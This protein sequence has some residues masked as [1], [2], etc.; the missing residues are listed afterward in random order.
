MNP[1]L[2]DLI[3]AADAHQTWQWVATFEPAD[4]PATGG[5]GVIVTMVQAA[6]G[7]CL[8]LARHERAPAPHQHVAE[9]LAVLLEGRLF[10]PLGRDAP[11]GPL[12]AA[13]PAAL[14]ADAY[15]RH[16]A[17][18]VRDLRGAFG[19]V[20]WDSRAGLLLAARDPLGSHPFYFAA[21]ADSL[22]F[23]SSIDALLADG[24]LP[25]TL[26]RPAIVDRLLHRHRWLED[27]YF[28]AIHRLPPG[29]VLTVQDSRQVLRRYWDPAPPGQVVEW[30]REE[31]LPRF[32]TL[33]DAAVARGLDFGPVGVFLSGG[34]DSVTVA[35][36]A[37][38]FSR[39]RGL[40]MPR[41]YSMVFPPPMDERAVQEQAA[42]RLG[43]PQ[44]IADFAA[45]V[46]PEGVIQ[47]GLALSRTWPWPILNPWLP[48]FAALGL[49]A[50]EQGVRA[51]LSGEGGDEWLS[52]S[53]YLA[54]DLMAAGDL[55]GLW[56]LYRTLY[57]SYPWRAGRL[58]RDLT[59]QFGLRPIIGRQGRHVLRRVAPNRL[60]ARWRAIER[61][62]VPEWLAPDPDLRR[63][64]EARIDRWVAQ[65]WAAPA[66]QGYYIPDIRE[67]LD[68][69]IRAVELEE[70]HEFGR[71]WGV[72]NLQPYWDADLVDFLLRT[73]PQFLSANGRAK[74][75]IRQTLAKRLPG[76]GFE[77]Q[78]KVVFNTFFVDLM[79]GEGRRAWQQLGGAQAM[80]DHGLAD[81]KRLNE[82]MAATFAG[83]RSGDI[84]RSH[85]VLNLEVWL[86]SQS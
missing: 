50:R 41:A 61:D 47:R 2:A 31:E 73:P 28:A 6:A 26:N 12:A 78:R 40:P 45:L 15:R 68:S 39:Q 67:I 37:A 86:R 63:E 72:K 51:I 25:R 13:N 48:A 4:R 5:A 66:R 21:Q 70:A 42:A 22:Y 36:L 17:D 46:G 62:V 71:R 20:L 56:R 35:A 19:L 83:S 85:D 60:R 81:P 3:G 77:R 11:P 59:W 75:L 44:Q 27:T 64:I 14:V 29:H 1:D 18:F 74:I 65:R 53:P 76:L 57:L 10:P 8:R 23:A 34:L 30:V 9:G 24:H 32:E 82:A 69:I 80:A 33:L 38:D 84:A 16:G 43:L 7:R 58:A 55:A 49:S 79:R 54:S 52:V